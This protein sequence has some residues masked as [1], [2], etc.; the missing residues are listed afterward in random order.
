[1]YKLEFLEIAKKD[2]EDIIC[3]VTYNLKNKTAAI[4]LSKE[5]IK[6]ANNIL[7]FPYGIS[8]YKPK[9]KLKYTYRSFKIKNFL[10]F[11]TINEKDKIITI[12]RV[13]YQKMDINNILE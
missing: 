13:I 3:Y 8:E 1:M 10:M 6:G 12:V 2:I 4:K 5:F 9:Y 7:D 11:Y